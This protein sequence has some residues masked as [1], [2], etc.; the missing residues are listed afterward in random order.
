MYPISRLLLFFHPPQRH[1][2]PWRVLPKTARFDRMCSLYTLH[3]PG[4]VGLTVGRRRISLG[5]SNRDRTLRWFCS[6]DS[7]LSLLEMLHGDQA[8]VPIMLLRGRSTMLSIAFAFLFLGSFVIPVYYLPEWFQI[9][10]TQ[11]FGSLV[12]GILGKDRIH[13][14]RFTRVYTDAILL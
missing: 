6:D 12:S 11:I 9:V 13:S 5:L 1:W 14:H 7:N 2:G 3:H 10:C 4:D 8:T